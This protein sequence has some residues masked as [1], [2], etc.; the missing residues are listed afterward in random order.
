MLNLMFIQPC[1][2]WFSEVNSLRIND[3]VY[4][5]TNFSKLIHS[6]FTFVYPEGIQAKTAYI[7]WLVAFKNC[8]VINYRHEC[9]C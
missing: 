2:P 8:A 6:T 9:K 3:Y 5:P 1:Y 7:F 4:L